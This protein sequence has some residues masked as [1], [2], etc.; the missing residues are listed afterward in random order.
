MRDR[1]L[2]LT[3]VLVAALGAATPSLAA[4]D[5][6][7]HNNRVAGTVLGAIAGGVI[8]GAVSHGNGGAVVGGVI[9]GGLAGN[10]IAGDIDCE[11]RPY[12]YHTYRVALDGRLGERYDWAHR[13]HHGYIV[14]HREY[15]R[16]DRLC[17]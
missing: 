11:D 15:W 8:G 17:R 4:A 10:A 12:A 1:S 14:A 5:E 16:G 9:L 3:A 2:K 7:H 6:C 13:G